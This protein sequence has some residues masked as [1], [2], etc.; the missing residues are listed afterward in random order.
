MENS[1]VIITILPVNDAP[2]LLYVS[3]PVLRANSAP[4]IT[5]NNTEMFQY[6]EDDPPLNF[7]HDIY[8]RDVDS[9]ISSATLQLSGKG[10]R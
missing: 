6:T 1:M 10:E 8:L 5:V 4:N 7:G 9:N 3:D 2:I